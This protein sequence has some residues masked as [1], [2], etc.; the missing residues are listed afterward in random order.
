[1]RKDSLYKNKVFE[2]NFARLFCSLLI[3]AFSSGL[4]YGQVDFKM[5]SNEGCTDF[6]VGFNITGIAPDS[7][8]WDFGNGKKGVGVSTFHVYNQPGIFLVRMTAYKDGDEHVASKNVTVHKTPKADFVFDKTQGCPPL[9]VMFTDKSTMGSSGIVKRTWAFSNGVVVEGNLT[10]TTQTFNSP[11]NRDISLIIEDENGCKSTVNYENALTVYPKPNVSFD[12]NNSNA[13][14]IPVTS[15]FTNSSDS[16]NSYAFLW[17]FGDNKSSSEVSPTHVY[18]KEGDYTITLTATDAKGCTNTFTKKNMIVDENFSV[19]IDISKTLGCDS[20][21]TTFKP[22]ISSL[23]R[24]LTWTIDPKLNPNMSNMT[25]SGDEPGEYSVKLEATSQFGCTISNTKIVR[26]DK[27]PIVDFTSKDTLSCTVPFTANFTNKS[28]YGEE[29]RWTFGNNT[30]S[31][32]INPQAIYNGFGEFNVRLTAT[33]K[34]GCVTGVVKS[35]FIKIVGPVVEI[36]GNAEG[37][38]PLSTSFSAKEVRGFDISTVQWD[39]G[40]GNT[41]TGINPPKQT[42]SSEGKYTVKAKVSFKEGCDPIT[43]TKIINVGS[44]QNINASI[45]ASAICPSEILKGEVSSLPNAQYKW[46]IGNFA[47]FNTRTFSY[48]FDRVGVFPVHVTVVTNGCETTKKVGEVSVKPSIANFAVTNNCSGG[49]VIFRN[50]S[51]TVEST[52]DFGDGTVV[53]NNNSTVEHVYNSYGTYN[54]KLTV[55]N[56]QNG[57]KDVLERTVVVRESETDGFILQST[58]GCAP[59][60]INYSSLD[61]SSLNFWIVSGDTIRGKNIKHIVDKPGIHDVTLITSVYGCRDTLLF[62]DLIEVYKPEAG[63]KFSPIGGCAPVFSTF[64]DTSKSTHSNIIKHNWRIGNFD[65]KTDVTNFDYNFNFEAIIP[66][67]LVIEDNKGCTDS[68]THDLIVARPFSEF[69]LPT[70][71]FCTGNAFKPENLSTGVG[72]QYYWNFGDGTPIDTSQHPEHFYTQEGVYDIELKLIDDNNCTHTKKVKNAVTIQDIDYDFTAFP[73]S[74]YCPELLTNFSIIPQDIVYRQTIWDFGD[75]SVVKDTTRNPKYVYLNAGVYDVTLSLEDYRGCKEVIKKEKLIDL[76]G[77]SGRFNVVQKSIC[78]PTEVEIT[79][80][81]KNSI[82]NFW[83]YGD[84]TVIYDTNPTPKVI[85]QYKKPGKYRPSV[86]LDDGLGCVSTIYGPEIIVGG[87]SPIISKTFDVACS[88][89]EVEF[90][91]LSTYLEE[92]PIVRRK[93]SFSDGYSTTD[94]LFSRFISVEDSLEIYVSLEVEDSL[95]CI[96]VEEDTLFVFKK[97][98]LQVVPEMVICKGDS[99]RLS[100]SRVRYYEWDVSGSLAETDIPN[101]LA[102]PLQDTEYRVRGYVSPTCFTDKVIH[103]E[104]REAFLGTAGTDTVVCVGDPTKLWVEHDKI[105]SGR[106]LYTWTI[107]GELISNKKQLDVTPDTSTIY[108]INV[109]NGACKDFNKYVTVEVSEYPDLTVEGENTILIGQEIKL[110]A[111]SEPGVSYKWEP[112]P[113]SGCKNCPFAFV[114]P[115]SSTVYTVTVTNRHGCT[116]S[117]DI[118]VDVATGCDGSSIEIQ[119]IFTPNNDGLNDF[120]TLRNNQLIQLDKIRIYSR[121]GELVYISSNINDSWDGTFNGTPLNSGVYVYYVEAHCKNGSP[122]L[123]KGNI[124]LVR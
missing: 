96:S 4:S 51:R 87:P 61:S 47:E 118:L 1:M 38:T 66:V 42:Y 41:Y 18:T 30:A 27:K 101:P 43:V 93:W 89:E 34:Y 59:L 54:V 48:K 20:L 25:L 95:G 23:Y 81:I 13:C 115:T 46:T 78:A 97:A 58:K 79:A 71:S 122:I 11:G 16:L 63:F 7:V 56:K 50:N 69:E 91:D 29:Y 84:G 86:T 120:F 37:C 92:A 2:K 14:D 85:H 21:F 112:E 3:L 39:F 114:S 62:K 12:F 76:T 8:F 10:S 74:K 53:S 15:I 31:T 68:V 22:V 100:A 77:P 73:T 57:C 111:K 35:R 40:N 104:V 26:I 55:H 107:D 19:N 33:S 6:N 75:G 9:N 45:S 88:N 119:N 113:S 106:F 70:A 72:L 105:H 124:T 60:E 102:F 90:I 17:D 82:A 99:V 67:L 36:T 109:H 80:D 116:V 32:D 108:K 123:L 103:V 98:P 94:S 117:E 83:D 44:A 49:R 24:K 28:I 64:E 65:K 110:E 121:T 5:S 52:W